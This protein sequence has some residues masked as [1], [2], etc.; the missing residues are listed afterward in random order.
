MFAII[1]QLPRGYTYSSRLFRLSHM[2]IQTRHHTQYALRYKQDQHRSNRS[3]SLQQQAGNRQPKRLA[4]EGDQAVDAIDTALQ[5]VRDDAQAVAVG[6]DPEDGHDGEADD[7][8]KA[9][10]K[11]VG[12]EGIVQ[13]ED[14]PQPGGPE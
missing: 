7:V 6:D 5:F 13:P 4:A 14:G 10:D 8:D 9:Q 12:N 11:R 1:G 3:N 2:L